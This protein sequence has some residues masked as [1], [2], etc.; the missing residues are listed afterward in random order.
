M[1]RPFAGLGTTPRTRNAATSMARGG[2]SES[3]SYPS[4]CRS[5]VAVYG[6]YSTV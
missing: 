1:L 2:F 4:S 5:F 3:G 6:A